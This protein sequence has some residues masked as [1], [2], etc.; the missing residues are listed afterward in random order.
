MMPY[1]GASL[2]DNANSIVYGRNM[3]MI[4]ATVT[5]LDK[6]CGRVRCHD[7]DHYIFSSFLAG[8]A[9]ILKFL[10]W[11]KGLLAEWEGSVPL[12]S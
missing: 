2:T 6:S 8:R 4:Q 5:V 11:P 10:L 12:T 3:I 9:P 1:F 7:R